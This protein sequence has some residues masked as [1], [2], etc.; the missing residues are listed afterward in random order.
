MAALI[1]TAAFRTRSIMPPGDVDAL[2][3]VRPGFIAARLDIRTGEIHARLAKRYATPFSSD[4]P[5]DAVV[6]WLVALVTLDAFLARGFNPSSQQDGLIEADAARARDS[7]KEAADSK[8]G[9][10]DLPLRESS[11]G[12]SGV[13]LGGPLGYSEAS[14]YRSID[15]QWEAVRDE[16]GL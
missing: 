8:D 11:Q 13:T 14:P 15:A 4:L 2:E 3:T 1:T 6:G 7:I 9:L 16:G 5:P 12:E 10:F